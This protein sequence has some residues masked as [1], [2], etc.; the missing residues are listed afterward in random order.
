METSVI[1]CG[2]DSGTMYAAAARDGGA[3]RR[4]A[5]AAGVRAVEE[6]WWVIGLLPRARAFEVYAKLTV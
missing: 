3:R 5:G 6:K 2:H 1:Y 4:R